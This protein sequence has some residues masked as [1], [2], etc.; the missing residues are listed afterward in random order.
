[1]LPLLYF[2]GLSREHIF[3]LSS[4][5]TS[6]FII[7]EILRFK[8][9]ASGELFNK[10]FGP[11][12]RE[13]EF[14]HV[15]GATYLFISATISFLIFDK[16]IAIAAVLILTVADSFAA[17]VGKI[18][19]SPKFISKS[20]AGS[21]TFMI[22]SMIILLMIFPEI[23]IQV[24]FVVVPVTLLEA[25]RMPINDNIVISISSGLLLTLIV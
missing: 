5:I 12:L 9:R 3:I 21:T 11:L 6:V 4:S 19:V 20:V 22:M 16:P 24:L 7:F 2:I 17:V 18:L 14:N 10:I 25:V 13:E 15:T 23:G 8:H 1:M